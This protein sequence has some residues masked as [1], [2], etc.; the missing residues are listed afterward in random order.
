ML[1]SKLHTININIRNIHYTFAVIDITVTETTIHTISTTDQLGY[2][3]FVI[4]DML[5]LSG[6]EL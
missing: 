2:L 5:I 4:S 3:V 6:Q 1:V